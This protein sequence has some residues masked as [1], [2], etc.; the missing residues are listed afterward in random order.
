LQL[1]SDFTLGDDL[2]SDGRRDCEL[3][4][5]CGCGHNFEFDRDLYVRLAGRSEESRELRAP[6]RQ[7]DFGL[8]GIAADY[9]AG[10][11]L[12]GSYVL[13]SN[14]CDGPVTS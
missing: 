10:E 11:E 13:E 2:Q 1:Q 9:G 6:V 8:G 12:G 3:I 7:M 14:L 4:G 5:P